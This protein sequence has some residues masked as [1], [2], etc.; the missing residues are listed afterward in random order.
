MSLRS[1]L[2][3]LS[4][5]TESGASQP[6]DALDFR[7]RELHEASPTL[8]DD[9]ASTADILALRRQLTQ[10]IRK[11]G[12]VPLTLVEGRYHLLLQ[13]PGAMLLGVEPLGTEG[14]AAR[15]AGLARIRGKARFMALSEDGFRRAPGSFVSTVF[16]FDGATGELSHDVTDPWIAAIERPGALQKTFIT[17]LYRLARAHWPVERIDLVP[18]WRRHLHHLVYLQQTVEGIDRALA[19]GDILGADRS[20]AKMEALRRDL[21][22]FLLKHPPD[23]PKVIA[24]KAKI[25]AFEAEVARLDRN[26]ANLGEDIRRSPKAVQIREHMQD[27]VALGAEARLYVVPAASFCAV[28]DRVLSYV[29]QAAWGLP[30]DFPRDDTS[31]PLSFSLNLPE[32]VDRGEAQWRELANRTTAFPEMLP[33][34]S[35]AIMPDKPLEASCLAAASFGTKIV[36]EEEVLRNGGEGAIVRVWLDAL[37]LRR[38]GTAVAL[39]AIE[40]PGKRHVLCSPVF[41]RFSKAF[42]NLDLSMA[43][44][45]WP[46]HIWLDGS[47]VLPWVIHA[48]VAWIVDCREFLVGD[49]PSHREMRSVR[50]KEKLEPS[51]R[52][53]PYY[54]VTLDDTARL[55]R[56]V[57]AMGVAVG[58]LD[59]EGVPVKVVRV[60]SHRWDVCR[61]ERVYVRKGAFSMDDQEKLKE[62]GYR[63]YPPGAEPDDLDLDRLLRRGKARREPGEWLAIHAVEIAESIRGPS[64]KPYIP[65]R[66]HVVADPDLR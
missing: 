41:L 12:D 50:G 60:W 31:V 52:P 13:A 55:M 33:F 58:L 9:G 19:N 48:L 4:G 49:A 47:S 30:A 44:P 11:I 21:D 23:H 10:G 65:A 22:T 16:L 63:L 40:E 57:D 34:P 45:E 51:F 39:L 20:R 36:D 53:Q 25:E 42:T 28:W 26:V 6:P 46:P 1:R 64:D 24:T 56:G 38:D 2:N 17:A 5:L 32:D 8:V 59:E 43:T 66:R 29:V 15:A 37:W 14:M 7:N 61:H 35:I 62:R 54:R 3:Q 27:L 18:A